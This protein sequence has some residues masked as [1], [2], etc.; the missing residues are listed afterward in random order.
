MWWDGESKTHPT[1]CVVLGRIFKAGE[2]I[3]AELTLKAVVL[4]G[5]SVGRVFLKRSRL[6]LMKGSLVAFFQDCWPLQG[7]LLPVTLA[8]SYH[9][10]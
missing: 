9:H 6:R 10:H 7:S 8:I 3:A 1:D 4:F 2:F 5:A